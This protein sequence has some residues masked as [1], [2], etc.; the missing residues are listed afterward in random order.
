MFYA[1]RT[2]NGRE[3]LVIDMIGSKIKTE[4]IPIKSIFHPA[5]IKGYIFIEGN[6]DDVKKAIHGLMNIKGVIETPV[7]FDEIKNFIEQRGTRVKINV[8]D[9]VEIVGG[10][11]KNETGKI[12]RIDEVKD[13]VTVELLEAAIPIPVTIST[14]FVKLIKRAKTETEE[15]EEKHE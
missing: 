12:T 2:T 9:V 7:K 1:V 4:N 5:E 10:P 15:G 14:E 3:D 11:F 6:I 13:E 8:G